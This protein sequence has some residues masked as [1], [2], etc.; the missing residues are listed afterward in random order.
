[1]VVKQI[2]TKKSK[3]MMENLKRKNIDN[4]EIKNIEDL[5]YQINEQMQDLKE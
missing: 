3:N 2:G 5:N 4:Q 1:M